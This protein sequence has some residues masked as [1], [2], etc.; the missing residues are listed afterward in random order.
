MGMSVNFQ[1]KQKSSKINEN[2]NDCECKLYFNPFKISKNKFMCLI[3]L[4]K[5]V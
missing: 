2:K 4:Q 1:Y 5:L 3:L